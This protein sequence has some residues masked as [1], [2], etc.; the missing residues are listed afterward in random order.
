MAKRKKLDRDNFSE[1]QE[2]LI[3][4]VEESGESYRAASMAAG[5][6]SAT[7]SS[8]MRLGVRPMRSACIALADHFGI[9]PN[10][11]LEAAGYAPLRFFDR[12]LVPDKLS[13]EAIDLARLVD[14]IENWEARRCAVQA[15]RDLLRVSVSAKID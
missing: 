3:R 5:L 7:I 14:Q 10:V 15:V 11:M 9:N 1:Y 2:L 12:T 8:H 13:L 4:L 6:S